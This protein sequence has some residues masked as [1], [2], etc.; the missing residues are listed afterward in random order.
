MWQCCAAAPYVWPQLLQKCCSNDISTAC[1]S[2]PLLAGGLLRTGQG[3]SQ[4]FISA[5]LLAT[6]CEGLQAGSLA[7]VP[8]LQHH[9]HWQKTEMQC[10]LG[11]RVM[12]AGQG[13]EDHACGKLGVGCR[14]GLGLEWW[15][16]CPA[17]KATGNSFWRDLHWQMYAKPPPIWSKCRFAPVQCFK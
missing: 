5:Y 12:P 6:F 13:P 1:D 10:K 4:I 3:S 15:R 16:V 9:P 17:T 8:G 2:E 14:V 11:S 7:Q